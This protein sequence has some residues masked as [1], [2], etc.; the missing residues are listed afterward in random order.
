MW[1]FLIA[2]H[3]KKACTQC[4]KLQYKVGIREGDFWAVLALLILQQY[5]ALKENYNFKVKSTV[6]FWTDKEIVISLCKTME[7]QSYCNSEENVPFGRHQL[8]KDDLKKATISA[9]DISESFDNFPYYLRYTLTLQ[10]LFCVIQNIIYIH[11][12]VHWVKF[13][14]CL[15]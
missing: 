5:T 11:V 2:L 6:C 12:A 3:L 7:E 15:K 10:Q 8:L 14:K 4:W 1:Y 9:S 13:L